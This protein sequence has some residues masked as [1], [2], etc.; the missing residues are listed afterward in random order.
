MNHYWIDPKGKIYHAPKGHIDFV[1]EHASM[2]GVPSFDPGPDYDENDYFD[3]NFDKIMKDGWVRIF[4]FINLLEVTV[5]RS[6][7]KLFDKL[8]V[9]LVNTRGELPRIEKVTVISLSPRMDQHT[10]FIGSVDKLISG[11]TSFNESLGESYGKGAEDFKKLYHK[12]INEA[13]A[14]YDEAKAYERKQHIIPGEYTLLSPEQKKKI[15]S[16]YMQGGSTG[17]KFFND[18]KKIHR[19]DGPAHITTLGLYWMKNDVLHREDGPASIT[20]LSYR[21]VRRWYVKGIL[22][23]ID[24][25]AVEYFDFDHPEWAEFYV[26]GKKMTKEEFLQHFDLKESEIHDNESEYSLSNSEWY[27]RF[28][29]LFGKYSSEARE[30]VMKAF[31]IRKLK[32]PFVNLK[33]G[34]VILPEV[35]KR[36]HGAYAINY[37]NKMTEFY[38]LDENGEYSRLDGG[39][40]E[41]KNGMLRWS[42]HGRTHKDNGP[43]VIYA[44]KFN[45]AEFWVNGREMDKKEFEKHFDIKEFLNESSTAE[46]MALLNVMYHKYSKEAEVI[47]KEALA[48]EKLNSHQKHGEPGIL[49][50]TP[51]RVKQTGS[52][53]ISRSDSR[54]SFWKLKGVGAQSYL[55]RLDGPAEISPYTII[56]KVNGKNHREDGPAQITKYGGARY[57]INDR[58]IPQ[59]EYEKHFDIKESLNEGT[60]AYDNCGTTRS[61]RLKITRKYE[62]EAQDFLKTCMKE[63]GSKNRENGQEAIPEKYLREYGA[64]EISFNQNYGIYIFLDDRNRKNRLN[65]PAHVKK[66]GYAAW[67]RN[68]VLHREDGPA[69]INSDSGSAFYINGISMNKEKYE[70]HFDIKEDKGKFRDLLFSL[71]E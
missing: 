55:H 50:L 58:Q 2:F 4:N 12:Y 7:K 20:N 3:D 9:F 5:E 27:D 17:A 47:F 42:I 59:E 11:E 37:G 51:E 18:K 61:Y 45:G 53:F 64:N 30:I 57:F 34:H 60:E 44:A 48:E 71:S 10:Y 41:I 29:G 70:I 21:K 23:R 40:A 16:T 28:M 24:G 15:G 63:N 38:F 31:R 32:P 6:N 65:G 19:E 67:Y 46:N 66:D 43:A 69:I 39:P 33:F 25:P 49:W 52:D 36:K 26:N 62:K 56:W 8:M 1:M 14:I 54:Y 22:H 35:L 13:H 68:G